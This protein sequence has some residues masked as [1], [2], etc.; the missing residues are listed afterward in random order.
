METETLFLLDRNAV[1]LIKDAVAGRE[2]PNAKKQADLVTLRALDVPQHSISALLSIM[3]GARGN[4]DS[5]GEKVDCL[6][7]ETDAIAEFFLRARTDSVYLRVLSNL[8]AQIFTGSRESQWDERAE[9]LVKAAPLVVQKIAARKRRGVENELV[10]LALETSLAAND[11]IV[12]LFLACLYGNDAARKVI[13]PTEPNAYNVLS[14]V[15]AISRVGMVK[16]AARQISRPIKVRFHTLD[17]GLR[18]V[19]KHVDIVRPRFT[20]AGGLA[21]QMRYGLRLF[22]ELAATESIAL[23]QR[24]EDA[25]VK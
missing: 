25:A 7:E 16:A 23:L 15:H 18:D 6:I 2:P 4:A 24:L 10:S 3:E 20:S 1:S 9:F 19:L 14:D 17:E 11:A 21:M 22:P 12:M 8:V 5:I 13:K